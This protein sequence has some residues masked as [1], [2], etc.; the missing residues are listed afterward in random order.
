VSLP[1]Y[2]RMSDSDVAMV[3]DAVR[4]TFKALKR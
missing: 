1:L 2:P 3:L 4:D